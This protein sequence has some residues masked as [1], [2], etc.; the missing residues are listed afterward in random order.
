[1]AQRNPGAAEK[2]EEEARVGRLPD[3]RAQNYSTDHEVL[4][5]SDKRRLYQEI[6][7]LA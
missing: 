6:G 7:M 1:M 2:A 4:V 5:A 3:E